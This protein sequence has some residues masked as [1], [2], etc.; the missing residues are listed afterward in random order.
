MR[1]TAIKTTVAF[2][3]VTAVYLRAGTG[4]EVLLAGRCQPDVCL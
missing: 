2:Q 3:N 1:L 4:L